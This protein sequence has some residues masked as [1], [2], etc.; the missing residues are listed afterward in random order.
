MIGVK[1]KGVGEGL[2][3]G[4]AKEMK[5]DWK[6]RRKKR[7]GERREK[8]RFLVDIRD[9]GGSSS[10][11]STSGIVFGSSESKGVVENIYLSDVTGSSSSSSVNDV[12]PFTSPTKVWTKIDG[13]I[14]L[15]I[16]LANTVSA[17]IH[18]CHSNCIT[19]T[20]LIPL[21][22]YFDP[23]PSFFSQWKLNYRS[24]SLIYGTG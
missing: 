9:D 8:N 3:L 19:G 17:S 12:D 20:L 13:N 23:A 5:E 2:G 24:F 4:K 22:L 6:E 18:F 21:Q 1:R 10:G 14:Y 7:R 11:G 15:I 16:A